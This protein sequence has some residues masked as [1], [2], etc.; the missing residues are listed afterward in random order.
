VNITKAPSAA[1]PPFTNQIRVL[2]VDDH[3]LVRQGIALIIDRE[4]DM[5]VVASAASAAD[6]VAL[7]KQH[8]PDVT[9]MDLKLGRMSGLDAIRAIRQHSEA[10]H[11]VVLTMYDGDE[12]VY[13]AL[14]AGAATYL[15]KDM[16]SDDLINI[17]RE[18]VAGRRPLAAGI[19]ARLDERSTYIPLT[20]REIEVLDR[21]RLGLR[22]KE[23]GASLH[24]SEKTVQVHIKNLLLK[25]KVND[26]SAAVNV[27]LRRGIIHL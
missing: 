9:L 14:E 1:P 17:I 3:R 4:P 20:P 12:D 11:I 24:I 6:A 23:I 10:A 19:Q 16:L 5:T 2:C 13:R 26:R 18:V 7:F 8:L 27:A 15:L 25:L 21:V 22:N